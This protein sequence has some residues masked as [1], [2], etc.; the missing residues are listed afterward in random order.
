MAPVTMPPVEEAKSVFSRLG[1]DVSEDGTRLR[2]E[3]KWRTVDVVALDG[4]SALGPSPV[5]DGGVETESTLRCFVTW[6]DYAGD[7]RSQLERVN[8]TYDWAVIGVDADAEY[9][10]IRP[11]ETLT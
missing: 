5:A 1:Y 6:K 11:S 10:V 8:P 9:D 4:E 7:L 2:A 3:R